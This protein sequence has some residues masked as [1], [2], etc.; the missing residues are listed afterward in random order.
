ME[1][2]QAERWCDLLELVGS[3][4]FA[5]VV[6]LPLWAALVSFALLTASTLAYLWLLAIKK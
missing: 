1:S 4:L 2:S 5:G 3:M 6:L